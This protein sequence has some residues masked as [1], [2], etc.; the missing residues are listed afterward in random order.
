MRGDE[1]D[2]TRFVTA[3]LLRTVDGMAGH[4]ADEPVVGELQHH[5][6]IDHV[7]RVVQR[8]DGQRCRPRE[9]HLLGRGG[10][11]GG[12]GGRGGRLG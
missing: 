4:D 1:R 5:V 2:V 12:G 8:V 7:Q 9:R 10:G 11:G 6:G 3:G